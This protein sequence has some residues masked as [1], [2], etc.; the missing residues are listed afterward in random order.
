MAILLTC[1]RFVEGALSLPYTE[2]QS[3]LVETTPQLLFE[4][5]RDEA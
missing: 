2:C 3:E 5:W 1:Q 4:L